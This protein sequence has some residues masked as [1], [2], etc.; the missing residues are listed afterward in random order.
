MKHWPCWDSNPVP[1]DSYWIFFNS[2]RNFP[3]ETQTF[4]PELSSIKHSNFLIFP[5]LIF[6]I[7]WPTFYKVIRVEVFLLRQQVRIF[8]NTTFFSL[9][10]DIKRIER[11]IL[12][13]HIFSLQVH[14]GQNPSAVKSVHFYHFWWFLVILAIFGQLYHF[15]TTMI[16]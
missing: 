13:P 5:T 2:T 16:N 8:S 9:L 11:I 1:K 3:T 10:F 15:W 14:F 12:T 6:T 7:F 4:E